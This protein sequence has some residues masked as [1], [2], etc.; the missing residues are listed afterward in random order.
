MKGAKRHEPDREYERLVELAERLA[1]EIAISEPEWCGLAEDAEELARGVRA[2][3]AE[4]SRSG[5]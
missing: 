4:R 5:D 3:C 2:R 1:T